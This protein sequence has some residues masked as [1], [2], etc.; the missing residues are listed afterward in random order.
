MI[1]KHSIQKKKIIKQIRGLQIVIILLEALPKSGGACK[2][3]M[4]Y[5]SATVGVFVAVRPLWS[6]SHYL[7]LRLKRVLALSVLSDVIYMKIEHG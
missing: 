7:L 1:N 5:C 4:F 6:T 2:I 3:A